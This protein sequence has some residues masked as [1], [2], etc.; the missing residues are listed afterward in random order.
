M[1]R[2]FLC[3]GGVSSEVRYKEGESDSPTLERKGR[4]PRLEE[5]KEDVASDGSERVCLASVPAHSFLGFSACF[6]RK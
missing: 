3:G 4:S 2:L 1:L 6:E 5:R